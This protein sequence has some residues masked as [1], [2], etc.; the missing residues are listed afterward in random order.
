[1]LETYSLAWDLGFL[2][3]PVA[4]IQQEQ[5]NFLIAIERSFGLQRPMDVGVVIP[6]QDAISG[7]SAQFYPERPYG[8]TRPVVPRTGLSFSGR[9]RGS[10]IG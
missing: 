5:E 7:A 9:S 3:R 4:A 2:R 8:L 6:S 1:M 10:G